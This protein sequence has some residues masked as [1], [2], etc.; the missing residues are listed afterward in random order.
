MA[1][2][3]IVE[4][5]F[6]QLLYSQHSSFLSSIQSKDQ[7]AV[8]FAPISG[9]GSIASTLASAF[10]PLLV[11]AFGLPYLLVVA[12]L[13]LLCSAWCSDKAYEIAEQ[14]RE[15]LTRDRE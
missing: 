2:T 3:F 9:L 15:S 11:L 12:S 1:V 14:V 4:N 6:V 5:A 10:T 13:L 7:G 8:W